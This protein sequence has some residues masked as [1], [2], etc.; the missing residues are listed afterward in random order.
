MM[1]MITT[2]CAK[3]VFGFRDE[4]IFFSRQATKSAM[5]NELKLGELLNSGLGSIAKNSNNVFNFLVRQM[6]GPT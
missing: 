5:I 3:Q 6:E 1:M 2:F 4:E